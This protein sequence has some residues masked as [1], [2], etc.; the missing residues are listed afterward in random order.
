MNSGSRF[1]HLRV[2]KFRFRRRLAICR[3]FLSGFFG[4]GI[5]STA[6][7]RC[8]TFQR[9][10]ASDAR[11]ESAQKAFSALVF[12]QARAKP[13][14]HLKPRGAYPS[15][16]RGISPI[17]QKKKR[18]YRGLFVCMAKSSGPGRRQTAFANVIT[19]HS[20][21]RRKIEISRPKPR[22]PVPCSALFWLARYTP[23]R[24]AQGFCG[25]TQRQAPCWPTLIGPSEPARQAVIA[26]PG[27]RR[28][29]GGYGG[30]AAL[31]F[32]QALVSLARSKRMLPGREANRGLGCG[33]RGDSYR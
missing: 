8:K 20:P 16:V 19:P 33:G 11:I 14:H 9:L 21:P 24:K 12:L 3:M 22:R 2:G 4:V 17:G 29:M 31:C 32:G 5:I 26:V 15:S 25:P 28:G 6:M 10:L 7:L 27:L 18:K 13:V 1:Q 30:G 23:F